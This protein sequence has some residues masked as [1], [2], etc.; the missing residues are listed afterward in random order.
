MVLVPK[1]S[2]YACVFLAGALH[3]SLSHHCRG[4][5]VQFVVKLHQNVC[6]EHTFGTSGGPWE[7]NLRDL[8]RWCELIEETTHPKDVGDRT[9]FEMEAARHFAYMLF[10][11]RFRS[12]RDR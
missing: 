3:P 1:Y 2:G 7:F 11:D 9:D 8:L 5:L 10:V 4:A 6:I 12:H